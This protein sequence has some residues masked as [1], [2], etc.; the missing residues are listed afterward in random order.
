MRYY[1]H[2]HYS[3]CLER[4]M[5]IRV[6][7][8]YGRTFLVFPCQD[9]QSDDYDKNGMIEFFSPLIEEGKSFNL[10][11]A[12]NDLLSEARKQIKKWKILTFFSYVF[13]VLTILTV[14]IILIVVILI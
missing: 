2:T 5:N 6:Y 1:I 11:I 4:D 3:Q 7:G 10:K 12:L 9:G 8:H 13:E 14:S